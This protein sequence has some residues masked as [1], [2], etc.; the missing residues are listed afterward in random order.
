VPTGE[1]Q[2]RLADRARLA[3]TKVPPQITLWFWLAKV[4]STAQGEAT[5]DFLALHF[6][7]VIAGTIGAVFLVTALALQFSS[8]RYNPWLYWLAVAAVSVTGTMAADGMHVELGVPYAYSTAFYAV[9]LAAIF[10]VWYLTEGTLSIHSI[11]T[12]RREA[13][14]WATVMATFALGTALG[15]FSATTLN[16]GY[17]S[18]GV[19]F[20]VVIMIPVVA[21]WPLGLNAVVAFWF[22]YT[23]TRPL[24][25][26]FADWMGVSAQYGGLDLGRARVSL[27][28]AIPFVILVIYMALSRVDRRG[29]SATIQRQ[30]RHRAA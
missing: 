13:F 8:R 26:S 9:V 10:V 14:Y 18:A 7:A 29:E 5:S 22:A 12:W 17:F 2:D 25:A 15:D 3:A 21:R 6:G 19:L 28:L 16:L 1:V 27:I 4:I 11:N 30:P 23:V 24:G 20:A